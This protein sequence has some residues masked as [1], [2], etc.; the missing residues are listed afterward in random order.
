ESGEP[1]GYGEEGERIV[2]SFGRGIMPLIRYKTGDLV[3][4]V[5]HHTCTCGRTFDV[6]RGGIIGRVDDMKLIRGINV[7]PSS[8]EAIVR[9]FPEVDE[10]QVLITRER[11]IYDEIS[12]RCE[13][14]PGEEEGWPALATRLE[15]ALA[16]GHG[17]LRFNVVQAAPGELPRFE[18]KARRLVDKREVMA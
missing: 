15:A 9:E 10:F 14:R 7:Y 5:P 1:V 6:Y 12:V 18:L 8:V 17:G 16:G 2:T 4:R 11:G 13:L 3:R